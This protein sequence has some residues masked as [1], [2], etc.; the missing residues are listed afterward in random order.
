MVS[1]YNSA[2]NLGMDNTESSLIV[3]WGYIAAGYPLNANDKIVVITL[4]LQNLKTEFV[5]AE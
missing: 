3:S 5:F 4:D 1:R 2:T